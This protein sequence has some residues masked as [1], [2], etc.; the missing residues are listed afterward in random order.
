MLFWMI[1]I[2]TVKM[3]NKR[4]E[5][6]IISDLKMITIQVKNKLGQ[7]QSQ[8]PFSSAFRVQKDFDLS[9]LTN[10]NLT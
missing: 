1:I 7:R 2:L 6:V 4:L 3:F 9:D 10:P 8:T 5:E